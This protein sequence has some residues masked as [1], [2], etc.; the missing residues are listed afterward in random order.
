MV[1]SGPRSAQV[2]RYLTEVSSS[3]PSAP[4]SL[5]SGSAANTMIVPMITD[6]ISIITTEQEKTLFAVS[7]SS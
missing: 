1:A 6:A 2:R 7:L 5:E 4:I 3:S